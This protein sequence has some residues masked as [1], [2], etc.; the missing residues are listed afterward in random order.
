M[1]VRL[2]REYL[3]P[4]GRPIAAIVVLQLLGTMAALYLPSLNADIIDNGVATGDTA[5]IV[6][7]GG[8]MLA[9]TLVQIICSITAV[10]FGARTAMGFGRDVRAAV[11][12][13]VGSFSAREVT[14]FGAPSL[15]TRTTNDVQQVQMLVLLTLHADG[16]RR[17]SCAS[18]ASSW[19]CARTSGWP[20]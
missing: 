5:Y 17:R 4:Y 14:H 10:Y 2:L 6:R 18:A 19:R 16:R 15:I 12:H 7:T 8:V 9:V 20:G 11:F 1:L 3:R 13:R